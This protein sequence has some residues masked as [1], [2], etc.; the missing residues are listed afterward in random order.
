MIVIADVKLNNLDI[1]YKVKSQGSVAT[2]KAYD[3]FRMGNS[4][5]MVARNDG[6]LELYALE[7]NQLE[8]KA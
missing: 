1:L 3:F 7:G 8:M 2:M 4:E 5:L 6:V